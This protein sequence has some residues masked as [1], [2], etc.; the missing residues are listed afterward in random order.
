M[1]R[2]KPCMKKHTLN[3]V[4]E[5]PLLPLALS[6]ISVMLKKYSSGLDYASNVTPHLTTANGVAGVAVYGAER[7]TREQPSMKTL[8][9]TNSTIRKTNV[10]IQYLEG[11]A[12]NVCT[13][14]NC[15]TLLRDNGFT[16][17]RE[18][19]G[20]ACRNMDQI[21]RDF[22]RYFRTCVG[23]PGNSFIDLTKD[24]TGRRFLCL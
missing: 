22:P 3:C 23:Y 2:L 10:T 21:Y 14:P 7:Q 4:V 24:E 19:T 1:N 17:L 20:R 16:D 12:T 11:P 8:N 15:R 13:S 18:V 9:M 6:I 5:N